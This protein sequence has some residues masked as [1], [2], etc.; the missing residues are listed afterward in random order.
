MKKLM[1]R[2]R[3]QLILKNLHFNDNE[4]INLSDRLSKITPLLDIVKEI[5]K[6]AVVPD[7][8]V[9]ID[10]TLVPFRGRLKFKQYIPNKR[11]RFGIKLFKLCVQGGYT[12][13]FRVYCGKEKG[14]SSVAT[15]VVMSLMSSLLDKGRTLCTDNWYTSVALA[16]ELLKR[17]THL[18]GTLKSNR[19]NNPTDVTKA[20]LEK[21]E[22]IARESDT[23]IVVQKWRDKRDVLILS[24]KH[25]DEMETIQ[26]RNDTIQKPKSILDYNK[27]KAFI[28][29][30][31]QIKG[32]NSSLRKGNKWYRKL[33]F[34]VLTET[35]IVNA[36]HVFNK[37]SEKKISITDF[38]EQVVEGLTRVNIVPA[39][40]PEPQEDG[41]HKLVDTGRS[42]RRRC[43]RC[44]EILSKDEGRTYAMRKTPQSKFKCDACN[45]NFC[46]ECFFLVHKAMPVL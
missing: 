28:D 10:E 31:D 6:K 24:T 3:F 35:N 20:K 40:G 15:K 21:G 22:T 29:T 25:T 18:L 12:Y 45:K 14:K 43:H 7:E 26:R 5:Y 34:E 2:N 16:H 41:Q 32:Y 44:Y 30:S 17:K 36:L 4:N 38:K 42:A 19:K 11:H 9:C 33:A 46:L 13:D 1:S 23:G 27:S 8:T 37:L 39:P